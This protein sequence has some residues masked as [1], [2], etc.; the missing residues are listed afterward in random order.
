V[1]TIIN[2]CADRTRALIE[3]HTKDIEALAVKL[4][5]KETLDL[6]DIV[7]ILGVR[8]FPMSESMKDYYAEINKKNEPGTEKENEDQDKQSDEYDKDKDLKN[9]EPSDHGGPGLPLPHGKDSKEAET[10][11]NSYK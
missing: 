4:L 2:D 9:D 1:N 3:K 5:E 6:N 10:V 11:M 8:P 7:Q